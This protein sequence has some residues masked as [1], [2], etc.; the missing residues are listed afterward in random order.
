MVKHENRFFSYLFYRSFCF[1]SKFKCEKW[2]HG[3]ACCVVTLFMLFLLIGV[4]FF[5]RNCLSVYGLQMSA[6]EFYPGNIIFSGCLIYN[7]YRFLYK[8]RYKQIKKEM[9]TAKIYQ[10]RTGTIL[11]ISFMIVSFS[12]LVMTALWARSLMAD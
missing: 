7:Y 8:E 3:M 11:I 1:Y 12:F 4:Y 10:N 2:P 6:S 5:I 9:F